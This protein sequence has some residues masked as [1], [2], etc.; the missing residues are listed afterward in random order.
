MPVI[1]RIK[2]IKCK[3]NMSNK[4]I[5][6]VTGGSGLVGSALKKEIVKP[7]EWVFLD[8][9]T[10]LRIFS[11][12]K[13]CF[14]NIKPT[15]IV[16][17]A[18]VFGGLNFNIRSNLE[19]LRVNHQ[20]NDNVLKAAA[21]TE[22]VKKIMSCLS[23]C[24]FPEH[25]DRYPI[26]ETQLHQGLPHQT[27]LGYAYSKR[28]IDVLNKCYME[29]HRDKLFTSIIPCNIFGPHDNFNIEQ[30]HII[31]SI[32]HKIYN[33]KSLNSKELEVLGSGTPLRQFIFSS[34]IAKLIIWAIDHYEEREPI[35]FAPK[36]EY[37]IID[38][39]KMICKVADFDPIIKL[40][41]TNDGQK[42]KTSDNSKLLKYL[43]DFKFTP[44]EDSLKIT[45]DWFSNNYAHARI[46]KSTRIDD[47]IDGIDGIVKIKMMC[48]WCS[49]EHLL[50]IWDKM[51][52]GERAYTKNG[53]T[54]KM[55][56]DEISEDDADYIV[57]VNSTGRNPIPSVKNLKKTIFMKMEPIFVDSVWEY[58]HN[59]PEL[60]KARFSHLPGNYNNNEWHISKTL[61]QLMGESIVKSFDK[62]ISAVLSSKNFYTGH[63]I[64]LNF[65][66][67]AQH[68][69]PWHSY[70]SNVCGIDMS[71][72]KD[73]KG[74]LPWYEKDKALMPYKYTFNCE[75]AI[76][77]G[78]YT[79]KL[80]D[81]ILCE[82]LCF[83]HGH[84]DIK[85]HIDPRA[86][87]FLD[88]NNVEESI[89]IIKKSIESDLWNERIQYIREAK[90]KI[91]EETGFFPR[92]FA[93]IV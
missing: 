59:N 46:G 84:E 9:K 51:G 92:L 60:L 69:L 91:L 21:E 74:S 8:S 57:V 72:W 65:A 10:D 50:A 55:V 11:E 18:A 80:I 15:H 47:G 93:T 31:P 89:G 48:N 38:C 2:Q 42:I 78:Y 49:A 19:L 7:D 17:L 12:V 3:K 20:L 6:L 39:V 63:T 37:S 14:Q 35:T 61:P 81:A 86:Y 23:T 24:V 77:P 67:E 66:K 85:E 79:E 27:N 52:T 75:N 62:E 88:I 54:L 83:Y 22:S 29:K 4:R 58:I 33:A 36:E 76:L 87:V 41:Q 26:D 68:H 5:I 28:M 53:I 44:I 45:Y 25:V 71:E 34:D 56:G 73:Y 43:P 30:C 32:M 64:R 1:K 16:H 13:K 70:G 40:D 82:T 90:K